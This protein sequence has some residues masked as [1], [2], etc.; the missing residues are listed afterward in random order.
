MLCVKHPG[1]K[2][3]REWRVVYNPTEQVSTHVASSIEV[4]NGVPQEVFKIPLQ[5]IPEENFYGATVPEFIHK[6]IIGPCSQQAV[7]RQT[8]FK[9]LEGAGCENP[10]LKIDYSGIPLR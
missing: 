10:Y 3:E 9:L 1:F 4:I 5:D 2:E 8:F 7:L 6:V